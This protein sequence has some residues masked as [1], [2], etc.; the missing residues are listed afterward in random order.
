M[1]ITAFITW[2]I[3]PQRAILI[4]W[5][6]DTF[7]SRY[8]FYFLLIG[9]F[10]ATIFGVV[11]LLINAVIA[12]GLARLFDGTGTFQQL[13][14]CWGVMQL[15]F[16]LI[17]GLIMFVPSIFLPS[18]REF[19]RSTANIIISIII[20]LATIGVILYL[21][22]AEVVAF[23]AVEKFGVGKGFGILILLAVVIGIAGA[24]LSFGFQAVISNYF[25]Y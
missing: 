18:S 3:G 9:A 12:H 8:L 17:S 22:Y 14:Y 23:S 24:C 13:V 20:L 2:F 1:A 21:S 6:S 11:A 16:V 4:G 15:P 10:I 5:M 7:G 19:A 25:R